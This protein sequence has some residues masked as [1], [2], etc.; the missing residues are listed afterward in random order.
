VDA[1]SG[2]PHV[3]GLISDAEGMVLGDGGSALALVFGEAQHVLGHCF[4][5]L[6]GFH[7]DN[8]FWESLLKPFVVN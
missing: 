6:H 8:C 7:Y 1:L 4:L 3:L 5:V 2:I